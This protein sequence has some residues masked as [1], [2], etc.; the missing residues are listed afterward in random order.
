MVMILMSFNGLLVCVA[1]S[2]WDRIVMTAAKGSSKSQAFTCHGPSYWGIGFTDNSNPFYLFS[3]TNA[4]L[5]LLA[6]SARTVR[7]E[8]SLVIAL[9]AGI[10]TLMPI[11][12]P[13]E[14]GIDSR[15]TQTQ[16]TRIAPLT[17]DEIPTGTTLFRDPHS[18]KKMFSLP[19]GGR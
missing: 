12:E 7:E 16:A 4:G 14:P 15:V 6:P 2:C 8:Y 9:V 3:K 13:G 1:V 19:L 17:I 11:I 10:L 18:S 5:L